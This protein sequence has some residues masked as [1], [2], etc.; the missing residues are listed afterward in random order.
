MAVLFIEKTENGPEINFNSDNS[1]FTIRGESAP[2]NARLIYFPVLEWLE[3]NKKELISKNPL[4][5]RFSYDYLNSISLKYVYDLLKKLENFSENG[6]KV[7]VI[8][9]YMKDDDEMKENGEEFKRL[10]KLDFNIIERA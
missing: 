2:E 7:E 1:L 10:L 4:S 6:C 8:W 5:I 3:N 9:D